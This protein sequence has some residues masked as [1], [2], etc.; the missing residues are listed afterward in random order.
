MSDINYIIF[1]NIKITDWIKAIGVL[2][3]VPITL[4]SLYKL[5]KKD[6]THSENINKLTELV[7][8]QEE[9][10][11]SLKGQLDEMK[12]QTEELH[13]KN[14]FKIDENKMTEKSLKL[15]IQ[16][17]SDETIKKY[18]DL[19]TYV[20]Q[21]LKGLEDPITHQIEEFE[22]ASKELAEKKNNGFQFTIDPALRVKN[23]EKINNEDLFKV[24]VNHNSLEKER[25][26]ELFV[27]LEKAV[28]F[29]QY[30]KENLKPDINS[31]YERY[32]THEED[33]GEAVSNIQR[34]FESFVTT[35]VAQGVFPDQDPFIKEIDNLI[36]VWIKQDS[37]DCNV[38]EI[39][40]MRDNYVEPI[41]ISC[42]RYIPDQRCDLMLPYLTQAEGAFRNIGNLKSL[43]KKVIDNYK[44]NLQDSW[45][46]IL[47]IIAEF[48]E[49]DY[50]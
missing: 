27:K 38:R 14:L 10:N 25:K 45:D 28:A 48:K 13:K 15:D 40:F 9:I 49:E 1:E 4:V 23:I 39:Y 42:N 11:M 36:S 8:S 35:N 46:S 16:R 30:L 37:E 29:I 22:N 34:L 20:F 33:W 44:K 26:L 12:T 21:Q 50:E 18:D 17:Y 3:G 5:F 6:L 7:G 47:E 41:R 32:Q 43:L 31:I 2:L 24:F 19:Q